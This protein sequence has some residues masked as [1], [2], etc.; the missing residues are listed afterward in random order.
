[1]TDRNEKSTDFHEFLTLRRRRRILEFNNSDRRNLKRSRRLN[2]KENQKISNRQS[3][4]SNDHSK[5]IEMQRSRSFEERD[6]RH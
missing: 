3:Q 1:M 6:Q 2:I 4:D 5:S